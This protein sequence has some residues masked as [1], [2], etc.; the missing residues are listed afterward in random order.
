MPALWAAVAGS[1]TLA[2]MS[3]SNTSDDAVQEGL[4]RFRALRRELEAS[5]L[6]LAT[7]LDGRRFAF[8]ASLHNLELRLGG[9]VVVEHGGE[10][11]LGQVLAIEVTEAGAAQL[12]LAA[13]EESLHA[14]VTI[15]FARGRGALLEGGGAP[16]HDATV[17]AATVDE[18]RAW[19][20]RSRR[21]TAML[22]IGE[23]ALAPGVACEL[24]AAGFGRHT[25][26]C[27]QSGSGKTY[28]LGVVLERL[29]METALRVVVLDPNSDFTRLGAVSDGAERASAER[30]RSAAAGVAVHSAR[31]DGD[32]RLRLRLAEVEPAAQAALLR[33]DPVADREEYAE[34]AR[35]LA[36]GRPP[37]VAEMM[38]SPSAETRRLASRARSLGLED[39]CVW[40]GAQP[41]STLEAVRGDGARCVVV[42]L[43]SQAT[44]QEQAL[45][46]AAVLGE[47]WRRREERRPVL[48][49]IDEAHNVCPAR[50]ADA[51]TELATAHA[52]R[53][54]A[55]GR[56]FGL[57]LLVSTQRPQK[58][59]ENV[60]SQ[61]DNL[62]LMRLNSA[63][64]AAFAQSVFSFVPPQ[65]VEQAAAFRLGE[66]LVAG[67]ISPHPAL[68]RFGARISEQGG[69]DVPATWADREG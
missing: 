31:Q 22:D 3:V 37:T 33:L 2:A 56:K 20:R 15:R 9:Y 69:S 7:S 42:D 48:V 51:L 14:G 21:A 61:C 58:V 10:R 38:D 55:E 64:D 23:L 18:V 13:G 57:Y 30:Y 59:H 32:L 40:A 45:T 47:L 27:G 6:P 39:Y 62:I 25:F 17:R 24:D 29:F 16:F 52:V 68:V 35:L 49:V 8:Q 54:A 43:G 65:L 50:P 66:A 34:L 46:A 5:V 1:S 12:D 19:T 44:P 60:I 11:L 41:G 28:S 4:A 53:I 36:E 26:L 63:A 67:K